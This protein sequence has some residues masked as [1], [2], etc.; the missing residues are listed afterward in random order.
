MFFVVGGAL[1]LWLEEGA[2]ALLWVRED[3]TG[4]DLLGTPFLL[5][6]KGVAPGPTDGIHARYFA[7][8]R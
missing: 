6:E 4:R 8:P 1:G 5:W 7:R 3:G 2:A